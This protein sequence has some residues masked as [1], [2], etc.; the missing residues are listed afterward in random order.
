MGGD[1]FPFIRGR[2]FLARLGLGWLLSPPGFAWLRHTKVA[3]SGRGDGLP[4]GADAG[5]LDFILELAGLLLQVAGTAFEDF[6]LR[7]GFALRRGAAP[8]PADPFAQLE[9]G[10]EEQADEVDRKSTRLNS[11]HLGI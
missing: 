8:D 11:S 2:R 4:V 6:L 9:V 7:V 3:D 5:A 1:D 10:Q